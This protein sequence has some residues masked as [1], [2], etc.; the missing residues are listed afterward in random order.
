MGA[1]SEEFYLVDF[2]IN[3]T[4][5]LSSCCHPGPV[6]F[7]YVSKGTGLSTSDN[8]IPSIPL[9]PNSLKNTA[10]VKK[11]LPQKLEV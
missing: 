8:I 7:F 6:L 9:I 4:M 3:L 2:S 10:Q 5:P 1:L 11:N